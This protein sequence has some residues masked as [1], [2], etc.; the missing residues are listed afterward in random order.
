MNVSTGEQMITEKDI[1]I[2]KKFGTSDLS[3]GD[4]TSPK[5]LG[6]KKKKKKRKTTDS[7][8]SF[9]QEGK[10]I[11]EQ[12][13]MLE[14]QKSEEK[15]LIEKEAAMTEKSEAITSKK[16][17][18]N[19]LGPFKGTPTEES[20]SAES[21]SS[22]DDESDFENSVEYNNKPPYY[23]KKVVPQEF[24]GESQRYQEF[25]EK[26]FNPYLPIEEQ[27]DLFMQ[28]LPRGIGH[29]QCQVER[30]KKGM[31][32]IWPKYTLYLSDGNKYMLTAVKRSM[33]R[34]SNYMITIDQGQFS[35][36]SHGYLGKVRSNQIGSKYYFYDHNLSPGNA[37]DMNEVRMQL[38]AIEYDTQVPLISNNQPRNFRAVFPMVGKEEAFQDSE[39]YEETLLGIYE[40]FK[41]RGELRAQQ[42]LIYMENKQAKWNEQVQAHVLNFNG[43]VETASAKNF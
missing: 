24:N 42:D 31:N 34:T 12:L 22:G 17:L 38:G 29:V 10:Q 19:E 40:I 15:N 26:L 8:N 27:R 23:L 5:S 9:D 25:M 41:E 43:R 11:A 39:E 21:S 6:K 13:L 37:E 36:E 33:N 30:N 2:N 32:M 1:V 28:P 14:E 3:E 4:A 16:N 35:K 7:Q 20:S 18:S